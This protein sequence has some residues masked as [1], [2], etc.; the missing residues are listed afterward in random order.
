MNMI[1]ALTSFAAMALTAPAPA[2]VQDQEVIKFT[3]AKEGKAGAPVSGTVTI[4]IPEGWHAYQNPPTDKS[5]Q[6]PVTVT[7]PDKSVV[8]KSVKYPKGFMMDSFGTPSAVYEGTIKIPVSLVFKTP[9]KQTAKLKVLYM[10]CN[11]RTC[12]PPKFVNLTAPITI[13]KGP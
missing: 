7:S 8:L 13:K 10:Q 12:M 4:T 1:F 5:G 3:L 6:T 9:G 11:D 2:P